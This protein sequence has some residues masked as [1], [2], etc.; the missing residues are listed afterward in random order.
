M[1]LLEL[2]FEEACLLGAANTSEE[3]VRR[4]KQ[5]QVMLETFTAEQ[6]E[7]WK[8]VTLFDRYGGRKLQGAKVVNKTNP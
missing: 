2:P 8:L 6:K 5:E 4:A 7:A 3:E 1:N